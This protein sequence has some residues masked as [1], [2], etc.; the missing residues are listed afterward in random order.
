MKLCPNTPYLAIAV[1]AAGPW[2]FYATSALAAEIQREYRSARH[3]G[4]GDAGVASASGADAI[5]YNPASIANVKGL[6]NEVVLASPQVSVGEDTRKLYSEVKAKKDALDIAQDHVNKPQHVAAQN[7]SGVVFRRS[8]FGLLQS[9]QSDLFVGNDP[10]KGSTV[11]EARAVA[12]AGAYFA[13]A[14]GFLG[15]TLLLGTTLKIVQKAS[16]FISVSAATAERDLKGRKSDELMKE[17]TKRGTGVGAD[18]GLLWKLSASNS[19]PTFGLAVHNLGMKYRWP[20][21]GDRQGPAPEKQTVDVGL[22]FEPGTKQS[23]SLIEIDVR[24]V[25]NA[26]K[27]VIYKRIHLG[28]ELSFQNVVGFMGGLNQGFPTYGGFVNLRLVRIEGG[29]YSEEL[30]ELPGDRKGK[31]FFGRVSVG[32]VQ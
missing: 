19:K 5:F 10:I 31:R 29:L 20:L 28:G 27:E 12:R 25:F 8:A 22:S 1:L 4:M 15:D 6:L 13:L 23:S 30:G 32:W 11:A 18:V 16:A 14:R 3:L 7:F 9:A 26:S 2:S 24:D 21:P 17:Y